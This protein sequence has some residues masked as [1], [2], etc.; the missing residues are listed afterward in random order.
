MNTEKF[1]GK[2]HS[3]AKARPSY[4]DEA[5]EYIHN[6]APPGSVFADIGAGTGKFTVLLARYGYE[7]FAV[8]PNADMREQLAVELASFPDIKVID[9]TA[10]ATTL[11][12]HSVDII[13][14]AQALGWFALSDF[15]K[16]CHRIGKPGV[17]LIS[18]YNEMLGD[19]STPNR[20][21][22]SNKQATNIF[23][24]TPTMREFPNPV[25]YTR[26]KWLSYNASISDNPN[27]S[28]DGYDE[29]IAE[30]NSIF[31]REN[32]DGLLHRALTTKVF[33]ERTAK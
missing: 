6:L 24:K 19:N 15:R 29:H 25:F 10:E 27:L 22:L 9:G 23:F 33:V 20:N 26:E 28:D 32:I 4:P 21:R 1:T 14:F 11:L 13:V 12:N 16:E 5:L 30:I 3:Y 31:D 17:I 8:E 2:A 18:V 7:M